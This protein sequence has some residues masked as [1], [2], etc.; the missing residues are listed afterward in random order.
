M[1][2]AHR[3]LKVSGITHE[4]F[5]VSA[6]VGWVS[7]CCEHARQSSEMPWSWPGPATCLECIGAGRVTIVT[8][9]GT[10]IGLAYD[11]DE[12]DEHKTPDGTHAYKPFPSRG[13]HAY[14][15]TMTGRYSSR[16]DWG[17]ARPPTFWDDPFVPRV[18]WSR[19]REAVGALL[20][21]AESR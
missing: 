2:R 20:S 4:V 5:Y 9:F 1:E 11:G 21:E 6:F 17:S 19:I 10:P 14:Y 15:G 7:L 13:G 16:R 3:F 8:G 12:G 18:R